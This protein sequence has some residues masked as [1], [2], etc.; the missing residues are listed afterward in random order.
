MSPEQNLRIGILGDGQLGRMLAEAASR[1]GHECVCLGQEVGSPA[2]Q[3][4]AHSI[5]GEF[6]DPQALDHLMAQSDIITFEFENIPVFAL[7]YVL[8]Q[9]GRVFPGPEALRRTQDRFIEKSLVRDLGIETVAFLAI[10][11]VED[12]A[13]G[14]ETLGAPAL[15]KTRREGYDGK[16]Q[17]W[18]KNIGEADNAFAAIGSVPAILEARAEFESE[19]SLIAVRGQ[20]GAVAAYDLGEN[21]HENGILATTHVPAPQASRLQ[22]M[23]ETIAQKIMTAL[24][25]VG[26]MGIEFFVMKNGQLWLNEI[27]PRV[28]NSGHW[29]QDGAVCDQFENHIRAITGWPLGSTATLSPTRMH[30]LLGQ[31][32]ADLSQW[33]ENPEARL[34]LYGKTGARSGRK[35]GHVNLK[36]SA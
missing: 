35:M 25:Y 20:D 26:V 18:V 24:D 28:H 10:D 7:D 11:S 34:H 12:L 30:N 17:I 9:G 16:G 22:I 15:L 1:L 33:T 29:T 14:L 36:T 13:A 8:G 21:H 2:A 32:M 31:H 3:V 27:A 4:C 23:A 5:I 19:V 6:D